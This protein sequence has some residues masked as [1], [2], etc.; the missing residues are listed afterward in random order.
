MQ[1][2][3][4]EQRPLTGHPEVKDH[5]LLLGPGLRLTEEGQ[6]RRR[7]GAKQVGPAG[8][9]L[10]VDLRRGLVLE[11]TPRFVDVLQQ[12]VV[13][14]LV[15]EEVVAEV[16]ELGGKKEVTSELEM[17]FSIIPIVF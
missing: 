16:H 5:W 8:L 7:D 15:V 14:E 13:V 3:L 9:G 10:T 2:L 11:L 12:F 4:E 1:D 6:V 17:R